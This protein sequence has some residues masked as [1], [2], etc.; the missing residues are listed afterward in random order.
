MTS[1]KSG[2]TVNLLGPLGKPFD[3]AADF[4]TALIVAGGLGIA[5]VMFLAD[6]LAEKGG[7]TIILWGVRHSG[8]LF[9]LE[10]WKK[11]GV[12]VLKATEDGSDG[13]HG[14]ATDLL[15]AYLSESAPQQPVMGFACGPSPM[16]K[17]MQA[18]ARS[19]GFRW[20]ASLEE[21]MACGAGVCQGCAV[22]IGNEGF[23]M[24]CSDGPVFELGEIA[25]HD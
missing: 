16:L 14:R 17:A 5:P 22:R 6:R 4:E 19:T 18:T 11:K 3:L 20:Q 10:E 13:F 23:Q 7:K 12:K 8:E 1:L 9:G 15:A 2:D 24:V 25:F 21:R